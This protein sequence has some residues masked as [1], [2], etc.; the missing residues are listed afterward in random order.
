MT[1]ADGIQVGTGGTGKETLAAQSDDTFESIGEVAALLVGDRTD[2]KGAGGVGGA[3]QILTA[4]VVEQHIFPLDGA[5][6]LR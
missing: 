1:A 3:F 4:A 6:R 5:A 2:G